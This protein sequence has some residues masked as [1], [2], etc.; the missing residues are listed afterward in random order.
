MKADTVLMKEWNKGMVRS[1]L[2]VAK[3]A[4]KPELAAKTGLSVVTVNSLIAEMV[5]S[6]EV[7]QGESV[8]S[9]GGRPSAQYIYNE[10]YSLAVIIYGQQENS[11]NLIRLLVVNLY[12][13][14]LERKSEYY[15]N[16]TVDCF[17]PWI[18]EMIIK[19]AGVSMIA[20]GL[21]GEEEN[22]VILLNDYP[23][24][25]G[26]VFLKHYQE[27]YKVP[28]IYENDVNASVSGYYFRHMKPLQQ[29]MVGI[30]VP[31]IYNPG[32]GILIRGEIYHGAKNF[33]GEFKF[34]PM[35]YPW[36]E[37]D[38]SNKQQVSENLGRLLVMYSCIIAPD[39]FVL[40]GD[41][42]TQEI[43][44]GILEYAGDLLQDQFHPR[45]TFSEEYDKDFETGMIKLSLDYLENHQRVG[46]SLL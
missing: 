16:I 12:G 43:K 44:E 30:Y 46:R 24:I 2:K 41:F 21:P 7:L 35:P 27:K 4:T 39:Q 14:I 6:G 40:Y 26:D 45:I 31:R 29:N 10:N 19:Y 15:T 42:W 38:Y 32:A 33:A 13:E 36:K 5:E 20:F 9:N 22:Q 25:I 23:D 37:L 34:I 28:V 8:P 3:A 17:D 1:H 11:N 18:E